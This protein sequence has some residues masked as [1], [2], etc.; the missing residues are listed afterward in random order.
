[1]SLADITVPQLEEIVEGWIKYISKVFRDYSEKVW[2][3]L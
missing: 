2:L 1:M 3:C